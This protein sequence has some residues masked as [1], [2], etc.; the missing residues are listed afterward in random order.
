[1]VPLKLEMHS[2]NWYGWE[3]P[4][5]N[6]WVKSN[7]NDIRSHHGVVD[8]LLALKTRN[9]RFDPWLEKPG[10]EPVIPDRLEKPGIEPVIIET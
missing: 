8:K 7:T 1:M 4:F 3:I 10:I 6:I 9:H 2:Y 5:G